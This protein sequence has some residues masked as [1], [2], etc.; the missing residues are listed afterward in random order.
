MNHIDSSAGCILDCPPIDRER[1]PY[2]R[3]VHLVSL[4]RKDVLVC[5]IPLR[6]PAHTNS[7]AY[8]NA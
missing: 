2:P 3:A 1:S 4:V 6:T 7:G 5:Y 8:T